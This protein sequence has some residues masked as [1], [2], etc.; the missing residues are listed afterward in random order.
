[1]PDTYPMIGEGRRTAAVSVVITVYNDRAD[2]GPTLD[3]LAGQTVLPAEIVITDAGSTDGTLE[4]IESW[5]ARGLPIRLISAPGA[6]ISAGRNIAIRASCHSRIACTDAGCRP[7]P[8]WLE[9]LDG[10]LDDAGFVAGIW[11]VE[12]ETAFERCVG[13][14][15]HPSPDEH[16]DASS[17]TRSINR[18]LGRYYSLER[19]TGR[20]MAFEKSAWAAVGGFPEHLYA[21]E[22][23][24]FSAA[25]ST[26]VDHAVLEPRAVV[27]WRPHATWWATARIYSRYA[28]G[29]VRSLPRLHHLIRSGALLAM[30]AFVVLLLLVVA[31]AASGD[32]DHAPLVKICLLVIAA[33][34]LPGLVVPFVRSWRSDLPFHSYAW[35]IPLIVVMKDGANVVGATLGVWDMLL[36]RPQPSPF[37]QAPVAPASSAAVDG[38][39][40][41]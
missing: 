11:R 30:M 31:D 34:V 36:R 23:V 38:S 16:V 25:M 4:L 10:A 8:V 15:L 21:G 3:A 14:A 2:L 13:L 18:M 26:H 7:D 1:M 9:V 22:D 35:R 29:S 6:N 41:T 5:I 24:S 40:Q 37:R 28:R 27:A 33:I 12:G 19:A 39:R 17:S 32:I 20:S